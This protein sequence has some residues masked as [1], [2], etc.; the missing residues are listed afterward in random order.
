MNVLRR[1]LVL[2]MLSV[3]CTGA[4]TE[5]ANAGGSDAAGTPSAVDASVPMMDAAQDDADGADPDLIW[6]SDFETGDLSEWSSVQACPGGV[7]V[8]TSPVRSG[9]YAA[10]FSVADDDTHAKCA[11]VP[12]ENPRAQIVGPLGLFKPGDEVYIGFSTF[13]P[14]D[15]P[16]ITAWLQ[17]QEEYGPPFNGSPTIELDVFG[18]RLGMWSQQNGVETQIWLASNAIHKGTAWEDIV[19]HVKWSTD[20]NVGFVEIYY[21]GALQTFTDGKTRDYFATFVP[22]I[23][24]LLDSVYMNQY[25]KAGANLGTVALYHD[26]IRVGRTYASVAR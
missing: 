5:P 24:G 23:N 10:R 20:P 14:A 26:D 15:F 8:V 16:T 18:D 1:T 9:K 3:R 4:A 6:K 11:S 12:T 2:A 17:F 7:T 21:E 19:L 25:R 22:T 13:F